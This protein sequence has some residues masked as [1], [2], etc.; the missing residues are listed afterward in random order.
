[1]DSQQFWDLLR[2]NLEIPFDIGDIK[3]V[4]NSAGTLWIRMNNGET[5][6]V[7]LEQCVGCDDMNL[8]EL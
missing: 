3:E 5:Y 4:E 6:Y 1:M 2:E 8:L 7:S